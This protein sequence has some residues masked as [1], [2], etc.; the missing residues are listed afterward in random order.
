[1]TAAETVA[2]Y[3]DGWQNKRGDLSDVQL[4]DDFQFTAARSGL[5]GGR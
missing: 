4:A 3:Y 2:R 5:R 1:M